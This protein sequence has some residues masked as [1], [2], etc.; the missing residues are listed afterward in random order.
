MRCLLCDS[1]S[2]RIV[3]QHD[4][5]QIARCAGCKVLFAVNPPSQPDLNA[6]YDRGLLTGAPI[7][8]IG[9]GNGTPP[10]WKQREQMSI[11]ERMKRLGASGGT[12]LDVGAF[13]GMFM[14]NA[15]RLGFQVVGVEPIREA[16][17]HLSDTLG[18]A[19]VHGDLYSAAF[20]GENFA[21]VSLLDVIE[22]IYDPVAELQEVLRV[23]KPGGV[24]VM[25]TP[26]AGGLIQ[27]I[28]GTKRKLFGQPWCPIDDV[29]WHLW[30]FTPH[31]LRLC[32]EKAGFHVESVDSLEPSP[33]ST[34]LNSGSTGWKD[35]ALRVAAEASKVLHMSD[36]MVGFAR[37]EG[38]GVNY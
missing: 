15:K 33:L 26:N 13:S 34:N 8:S 1:K 36:R 10:E 17:L 4:G 23:L 21:A 11:L 20:P 12:L 25:T 18:L 29:P 28:V 19:A 6:L 27:R 14:Q 37:K 2:S 9:R 35:L 24:V 38:P 3:W 30:G 22:H 32:M 7:D 5:F 16:Y 31:T